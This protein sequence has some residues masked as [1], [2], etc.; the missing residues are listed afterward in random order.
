MGVTCIPAAIN[1]KA[2][3]QTIKLVLS[4]AERWLGVFEFCTIHD[5]LVQ[6]MNAYLDA[7]W[8][9]ACIEHSACR[10]WPTPRKWHR[11]TPEGSR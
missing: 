10:S 5:F 2:Y 6:Q 1:R 7:E 3:R 8:K 4:H 11:F 9:A